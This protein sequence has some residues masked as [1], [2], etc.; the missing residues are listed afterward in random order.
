MK[1]SVYLPAAAA[2]LLAALARPAAGRP[3]AA[4]EVVPEFE[5]VNRA[6]GRPLRLGDL[7][8]RIIV[9]DFFGYWCGPCQAASADLERGI[10]RYYAERAGNPAGLPVVV[11]AINVEPGH[12]ER[13]ADFVRRAGLEL[14]ADDVRHEA[15]ARFDEKNALPLVVVINGRA[16]LPGRKPWEL[17]YRKVGYEGAAAVRAV[18]DP[19]AAVRTPPG[20]AGR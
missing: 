11:I 7:A 18:I 2:V 12:P 3:V 19:L 14:T 15:L 5:V 17:L 4:G 8:G 20:G 10:G 13:T 1:K 6:S 9:L 16:D